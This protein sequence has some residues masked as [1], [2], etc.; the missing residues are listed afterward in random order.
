[1]QLVA[2]G[3]KRLDEIGIMPLNTMHI[4]RIMIKNNM[5]KLR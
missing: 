2:K 1:M 3:F 5:V 4:Q